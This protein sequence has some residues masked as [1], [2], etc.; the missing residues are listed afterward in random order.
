MLT[1]KN[2]T[3]NVKYVSYSNV[4]VTTNMLIILISAI[5]K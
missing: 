4:L 5:P 1:D 2:L 3:L